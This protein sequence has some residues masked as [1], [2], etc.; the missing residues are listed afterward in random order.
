MVRPL[1]TAII[2]GSEGQDG[3]LLFDRLRVERWCVIGIGRGSARVSH[4]HGEL[5]SIASKNEVERVFEQVNPNAVFYLPA[6]HSSSDMSIDEGD[7][8][9]FRRSL[10]LHVQF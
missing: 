7:D 9:L 8:S 5:F 4:G 2:V 10:D 3:R 6:I 1:K